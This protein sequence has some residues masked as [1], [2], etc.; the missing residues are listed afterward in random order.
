MLL[1]KYQYLTGIA[2]DKTIDITKF[3][4]TI[5][6]LDIC[7]KNI[8]CDENED[9]TNLFDLIKK[10]NNIFLKMDIEGGELPWLNCLTEEQISHFSQIVIEFHFPFSENDKNIF[11]KI[12]KTHILVHLHGNNCPAGVV[13]HKNVIIPNIFECTYINKKYININEIELNIEPLP[14]SIDM[15][16]C[17]GNDIDLNYSPFVNV[18][19]KPTYFKQYMKFT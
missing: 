10:N 2:F 3:Q 4:N 15:P 14:T 7:K 5:P 16:N 11:K 19:I 13:T 8:G 9:T 1:Q 6:N 18:F 17:H 12:N